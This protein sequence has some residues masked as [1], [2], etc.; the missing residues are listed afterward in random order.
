MFTE[1]VTAEEVSAF[2]SFLDATVISSE[3]LTSVTDRTAYLTCSSGTTSLFLDPD[4]GMRI[5]NSGLRRAH[6]YLM[7]DELVRLADDRP[8][9]LILVFDQSV[10]RGSERSQLESKLLYLARKHVYG[11]AYVSHACFLVVSADHATATEA[12][13]LLIAESRLPE[14]RFLPVPPALPHSAFSRVNQT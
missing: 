6:E 5:K 12:R 4:T 13:R 3:V 8:S 11:F 14:R 10:A 1:A 9:A 7:A 2:G